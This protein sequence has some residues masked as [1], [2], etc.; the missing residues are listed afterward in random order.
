MRFL[1]F[2]PY[3]SLFLVTTSCKVGHEYAGNALEKT[4]RTPGVR[5]NTKLGFILIFLKKAG[6]FYSS[7]SPSYFDM[8][9]MCQQLCEPPAVYCRAG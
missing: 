4:L 7:K 1:A 6:H 3:L 5:S 9:Q 2:S 8:P